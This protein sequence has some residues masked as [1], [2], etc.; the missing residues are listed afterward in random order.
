MYPQRAS[1]VSLVRHRLPSGGP[2]C[3][4]HVL[5]LRQQKPATALPAGRE[6]AKVI[7]FRV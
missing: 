7:P 6:T 4:L 2:P 1:G 5:A 3:K